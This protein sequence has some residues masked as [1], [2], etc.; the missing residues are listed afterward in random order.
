MSEFQAVQ[1]MNRKIDRLGFGACSGPKTVIVPHALIERHR[2][3][4]RIKQYIEQART[5]ML[6]AAKNHDYGT[7]YRCEIV[8]DELEV[9]LRRIE[10]ISGV[11]Q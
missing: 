8:V 4:S 7:A 6:R 9:L 11:G 10:Q 1:T 2:V 3:L 5:E